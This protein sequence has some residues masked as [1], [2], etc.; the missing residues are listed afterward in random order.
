MNSPQPKLI[1]I[2]GG[3]GA[4]KTWLA[5]R[6]ERELSPDASRISLD[7]FYHDFSNVAAAHRQ[8]INF[9]DP[10]AIDWLRM[11]SALRDCRAGRSIS[12]PQYDFVTHTRRSH[13][14]AIQPKRFVLV[15]GLWLLWRPSIRALFDLRI[16]LDCPAHIRWRQRLARDVIER[17]R[18][19]DSVREQFW[20]TV[21]PMHER[22]VAPQ[23]RWADIV[24]QQPLA[25]NEIPLLVAR[26]REWLLHARTP[27]LHKTHVLHA[28]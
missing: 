21:A 28:N 15:E 8:H 23:T 13:R 17:G 9:D 14:D 20:N 10:S 3:S 24:L 16:Y 12:A 25:E 11:E 6:L 22:F 18:T 5:E 7:N 4:G 19:A 1:A 26:I 27:R 2:V